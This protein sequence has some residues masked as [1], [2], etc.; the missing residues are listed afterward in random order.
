MTDESHGCSAFYELAFDVSAGGA[1]VSSV[2]FTVELLTPST[3][4]DNSATPSPPLFM[5]QWNHR[6]WG[7]RALSRGYAALV[8]PAAD[9]RDAAPAFQ[10]AY[11]RTATMAL[12][13]ARAFVASRALDFALSAPASLRL[14][15]F[16]AGR[17]CVTGHS[18]NGKQSLLFAAF[19]ERIGAVVG[20]SPGAPISSPYGFSSHNFY[21]E[22]P[23]AGTAGTW[24][25][26]SITRYEDNPDKLP[27]DG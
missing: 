10:R 7:L 13:V 2:N 27:M 16:Q 11:A 4:A 22:G 19:D 14:P 1:G 26:S 15:A 6:E 20:S 23:D 3:C 21:G 5:T 24:W 9:T 8:Y 17:I 25:L 18:R 12:I